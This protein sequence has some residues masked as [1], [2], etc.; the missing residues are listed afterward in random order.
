MNSEELIVENILK[1]MLN[2]NKIKFLTKKYKIP[3]YEKKS[4]DFFVKLNNNNNVIIEI[5]GENHF[6]NSSKILSKKQ[7]KDIKYTL[8]AIKNKY[9]IIRISY[10]D[11]KKAE[12]HINKAINENNIIPYF[13]DIILYKKIF[14][15]ENL[16]KGKFI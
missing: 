11:I 15:M 1:D 6:K 10:Y 16:Y 5:D 9:K 7:Y 4:F 2:N 13:S 12:Y 3:L 14:N 8:I